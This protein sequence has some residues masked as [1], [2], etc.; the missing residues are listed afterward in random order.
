MARSKPTPRH[1]AMQRSIV[2]FSE[3]K[4]YFERLKQKREYF[5]RVSCR[6]WV[7][8]EASLPGAFLEFIEAADAQTLV[9]AQ[10]S[11]PE[12]MLDP[13]RIYKEVEIT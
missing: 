9:D 2:P 4:K 3:R 13:N 7:F 12:R 8:E 11:A 1:L 10:A 5:E 6:F